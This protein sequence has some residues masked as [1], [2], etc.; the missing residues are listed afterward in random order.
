MA[1]RY[2][3]NHIS[4]R[5]FVSILFRTC[6]CELPSRSIS[7]VKLLLVVVVIVCRLWE[8]LLRVWPLCTIGLSLLFLLWNHNFWWSFT[9]DRPTILSML[10][11]KHFGLS[12]NLLVVI[13]SSA[14]VREVFSGKLGVDLLLLLNT[15]WM[16]LESGL[17]V[18]ELMAYSSLLWRS[19]PKSNFSVSLG[20]KV[21]QT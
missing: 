9:L 12:N 15:N 10:T 8:Q 17:P 21:I 4:Q 18:S 19:Y 5:P 13:H 1:D 2:D 6:H 3:I 11:L 20:A 7:R 16:V 14:F